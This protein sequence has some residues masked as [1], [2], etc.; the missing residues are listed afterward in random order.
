MNL[1]YPFTVSV[2][3][4]VQTFSVANGATQGLSSIF[5]GLSASIQLKRDKGYGA[6]V[7]FAAGT[8]TSASMPLWE[9]FIPNV[10]LGA[11]LEADM[12]TDQS[13]KQYKTDAVQWTPI[14]CMLG[15][16]PYQPNA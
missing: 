13:G 4:E 1:I 5:T 3:R 15:C 11:I 6:P 2:S 12:I 8:N 16:T 14:G 9:I 7:G 10:A